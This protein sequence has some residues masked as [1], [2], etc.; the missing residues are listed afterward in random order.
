[1][2]GEDEAAACARL[3]AGSEPWLT[4][5]RSYARALEIIRDPTREVTVAVRDGR[6]AGF[7]I[8]CMLGPFVG[9]I[10]TVAVAAEERGRG[11]GARLVAH[12]EARIFRESPNV[13][14][15]VSTFN[16]GARRLYQRLGYTEVGE[17]TDYLVRGHGEVLLRKSRGPWSEFAAGS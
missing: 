6:V 1:M 13:F 17:L 9:Y 3:M 14:M 10:Q 11:L 2:A 8:V 12:A 15:C 7:V 4:L 16:S 5:G